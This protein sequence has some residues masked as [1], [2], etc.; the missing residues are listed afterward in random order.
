VLYCKRRQ[1][2]KYLEVG[3]VT[4]NFYKQRAANLLSIGESIEDVAKAVGKSEQTVKLWL[5]ALAFRRALL[6]NAEGAATRVLI[7]YISGK[8]GGSKDRAMVALAVLKLGKVGR[9]KGSSNGLQDQ[10]DDPDGPDLLEFSEDQL[11][12]LGRKPPRG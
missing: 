5:I 8:A 4:I 3:G 1:I 6:E 12:R 2:C 10:D 11:R 7:E 9:P